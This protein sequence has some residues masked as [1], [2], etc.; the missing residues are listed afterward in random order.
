MT[1]DELLMQEDAKNLVAE[2]GFSPKDA[3]RA[4][5][6]NLR[7]G[8]D[9]GLIIDGEFVAPYSPI[10]TIRSEVLDE[11]D[12]LLYEQYGL[13]VARKKAA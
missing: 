12:R 4:V 13:S 9:V 6:T 11:A 10:T 1:H 7:A 2:R 5:Q 8:S 3:Q